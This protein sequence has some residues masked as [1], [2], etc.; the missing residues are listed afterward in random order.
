VGILTHILQRGVHAYHDVSKA[1]KAI[2]MELGKVIARAGHNAVDSVKNPTHIGRDWQGKNVSPGQTI[3]GIGKQAKDLSGVPGVVHAARQPGAGSIAMAAAGLPFIPGAKG[4]T[5][6]ALKEYTEAYHAAVKSG[7]IKAEKPLETAGQAHG[8]VRVSADYKREARIREREAHDLEQAQLRERLAGNPVTVKK[9]KTA[10]E[11]HR[12]AA[13]DPRWTRDI[14]EQHGT[15][16]IVLRGGDKNVK[17]LMDL[18]KDDKYPNVVHVGRPDRISGRA[19]PLLGM[20]SDGRHPYLVNKDGQIFVGSAGDG[21]ADVLQHMKDKG[22]VSKDE[23][24]TTKYA[25]GEIWSAQ[26]KAGSKDFIPARMT[27]NNVGRWDMMSGTEE[28]ASL[29]GLSEV[30]RTAVQ[31]WVSRSVKPHHLAPRS[32]EVVPHTGGVKFIDSSR[33]ETAA[34]RAATL[35][36]GAARSLKRKLD[37]IPNPNKPTLLQ[38]LGK[39]DERSRNAALQELGHPGVPQGAMPTLRRPGVRP[40]GMGHG[41]GKVD[42]PIPSMGANPGGAPF[43]KVGSGEGRRLDP[44][45][46]P[47]EQRPAKFVP[48][49][50][51]Q[52]AAREK[53]LAKQ[54]AE[55]AAE[56]ARK[57]LA[58]QRARDLGKKT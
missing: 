32:G 21:H 22:L 25:Q 38:A 28:K 48:R 4:L 1:N 12:E 53:E 7:L 19:N 50:Q 31:D 39:S 36:K 35:D 33:H 52:L 10:A 18:A 2:D 51:A 20:V 5:G 23:R 17:S 56:L 30:Q 26:G 58:R 37:A 15:N 9:T 3:L 42:A 41:I 34:E 47:K 6:R 43:K 11:K 16:G 54:K 27:T 49:T 45:T 46:A 44:S 57:R 8:R 40:G 14:L 13:A 24:L 55:A 29:Y